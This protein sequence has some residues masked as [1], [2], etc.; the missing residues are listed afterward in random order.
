MVVAA[1]CT[2]R[3]GDVV[4]DAADLW[5][6]YGYI[7][8]QIDHRYH[9]Q[10]WTASA[11]ELLS[12]RIFACCDFGKLCLQC[13]GFVVSSIRAEGRQVGSASCA[14]FPEQQLSLPCGLLREGCNLGDGGLDPRHR[15]ELFAV[16]QNAGVAVDDDVVRSIAMRDD[17]YFSL[18]QFGSVS[19]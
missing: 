2:W 9:R 7:A 6:R 17:A 16:P 8:L 11:A 1:D 13:P 19:L 15:R 5:N 3:L 18:V 12:D 14:R 10:G 4:C